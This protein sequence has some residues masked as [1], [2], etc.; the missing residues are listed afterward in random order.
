MGI[1]ALDNLMTVRMGYDCAMTKTWG[2]RKVDRLFG[3]RRS[4]EPDKLLRKR[5]SDKGIVCDDES[6]ATLGCDSGAGI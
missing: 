3:E 4:N 6:E 5:R 2:P 1:L